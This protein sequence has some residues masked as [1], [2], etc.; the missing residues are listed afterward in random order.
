MGCENLYVF[1]PSGPGDN[2]C[3]L[4]FNKYCTIVACNGAFKN[5]VMT[6]TWFPK[7]KGQYITSCQGNQPSL[8]YRCGAGFEADLKTSPV[9]CNYICRGSEKAV[10]DLDD[11]KYYQCYYNGAKYVPKLT[12][13]LIPLRFNPKT[14]QCEIKPAEPS[15]QAQTQSPSPSPTT[16]STRSPSPSSNP[17]SSP[18]STRSPP[19]TSNP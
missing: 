16:T 15:T 12:D 6:Y 11:T 2:Y 13:C 4:T 19:P 14:K 1:D 7:S 17:T 10:Y 3:R 9:E 18:A 5:F 8:V